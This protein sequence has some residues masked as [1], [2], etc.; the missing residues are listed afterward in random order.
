MSG[1][2]RLHAMR[3][4]M[5]SGDNSAR[6]VVHCQFFAVAFVELDVSLNPQISF[7]AAHAA[8]VPIY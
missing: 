7:C 2:A 3:I 4:H 5:H 6:N 1:L 8:N